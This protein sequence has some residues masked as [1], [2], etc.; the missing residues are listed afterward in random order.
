MCNIENERTTEMGNTTIA[1]TDFS[2]PLQFFKV[3]LSLESKNH[4]IWSSV[5]ANT[6]TKQKT[7]ATE[8]GMLRGATW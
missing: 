5:D 4:T 1:T 6:N 8:R 2:C 3:R 7:T